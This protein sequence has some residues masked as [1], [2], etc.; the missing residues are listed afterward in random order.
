M[1]TDTLNLDALFLPETVANPYPVYAELRAND[2][3]RWN[4]LTQM[5]MVSRYEDVLAVLQDDRRFISSWPLKRQLAAELSEQERA[6]WGY[7]MDVFSLMILNKDNP[8]HA[9]QRALVHKV[10]TPRTVMKLRERVVEMVDELLTKVEAKGTFEVIADLALPLP[11]TIIFDMC[12]VP[13]EL[14][15]AIKAG[16]DA[17]VTAFGLTNPAPGQLAQLAQ[18]VRTSERLLRELVNER[19]GSGGDD[20]LSLLLSAE[21]NGAVLTEDE[22]VAFIYLLVT[23]GFETTTNLIANGLVALLRNPE[24]LELL[25]ANPALLE[26]A[27]EELARYDSPV[28]VIF[29]M[30]NEDVTVGETQIPA[31]QMVMV[32]LAAANRDEE[33]YQ[34]ADQLDITRRAARHA[35]FGYGA[36]YCLGAPLARLEVQVALSEVLRRL[37]NLRL[38]SDTVDRAPDMIVRTVR[39]LPLAFDP[40]AWQQRA[41]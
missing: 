37:P 18:V 35:S 17:A 22:V 10:F 1:T 3:V 27:V 28:H 21:E 7:I 41:A 36:H 33:Q 12:G 26:G 11:A 34:D 5:W 8:E 24:Q 15:T 14:R 31:G 2:P 30:T 40:P 38:L 32:L 13:L 19:R 23:A 6:D 9:R 29:R 4:A 16:A 20:V 39:S 25:Q